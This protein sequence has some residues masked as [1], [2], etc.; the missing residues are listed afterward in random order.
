MA[1]ELSEFQ[2]KIK[3][4]TIV[5]N[6]RLNNDLSNLK[7]YLEQLFSDAPPEVR[8]ATS[9]EELD[10][11]ITGIKEGTSTNVKIARF[12]ELAEKLGLST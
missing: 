4:Q 1:N 12:L 5:D 2:K 10:E 3:A 8:A 9:K 7:P 11:L 6:M